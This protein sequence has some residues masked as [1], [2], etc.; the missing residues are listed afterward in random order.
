MQKDTGNHY[1]SRIASALERL[2]PKSPEKPDFT[3]NKAL[4]W[5]PSTKSFHPMKTRHSIKLEMLIGLEN[6]KQQLLTNTKSFA[7]GYP[8]NNALLWG[9]RG[10]GKSSL[11][12]AVH[13]HLL[14]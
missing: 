2:A 9:A 13:Q 8:A 4:I 1:L 7:E 6:Q 5:H 11:I 10:M 14:E 12:K 3:T